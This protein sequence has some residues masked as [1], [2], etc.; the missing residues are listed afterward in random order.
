MPVHFI[1]FHA[2]AGTVASAALSA[3]RNLVRKCQWK[4]HE[5][6][7]MEIGQYDCNTNRDAKH[8]G[9]FGKK[10]GLKIMEEEKQEMPVP[11]PVNLQM[12][13]HTIG[14]V[15]HKCIETARNSQFRIKVYTY[16]YI[17]IYNHI[18][19]YICPTK[20]YFN[21]GLDIF[22]LIQHIFFD[23]ATG[24]SKCSSSPLEGIQKKYSKQ[25]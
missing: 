21:G 12:K 11:S 10:P 25:K 1:S 13:V 22:F 23:Q 17:Y 16:I 6:K 2:R 7:S 15:S 19:I 18:Y 5:R 3:W 14:F 9:E 24:G 4:W 8:K 20:I